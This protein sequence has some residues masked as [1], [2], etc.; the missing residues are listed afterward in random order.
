MLIMLFKRTKEPERIR[1][2]VDGRWGHVRNQFH[3]VHWGTL[4]KAADRK[5][6]KTGKR[7][8]AGLTPLQ[9]VSRLL[10]PRSF[11]HQLGASCRGLILQAMSCP[12]A[13]KEPGGFPAACALLAKHGSW[14]RTVCPGEE[15][16]PCNGDIKTRCPLTALSPRL[17]S[18]PRGHSVL[19]QSSQ[20]EV[21]L[22]GLSLDVELDQWPPRSFG[23]SVLLGT[24]EGITG[25]KRSEWSQLNEVHNEVN[26]PSVVAGCGNLDRSHSWFV[27]W[28][29]MLSASVD[30]GHN[31]KH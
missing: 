1:P 18:A 11:Q 20:L 4:R 6:R 12:K 8:E 21:T 31:T 29:L 17:V 30:G 3:S 25:G 9:P 27:P 7:R 16:L 10:I 14:G 13:C 23:S 5:G 19:I 2:W 28:L 15:S 26:C 24:F 22:K